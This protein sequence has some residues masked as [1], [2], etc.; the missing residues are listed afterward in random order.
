MANQNGWTDRAYDAVYAWSNPAE[1][2]KVEQTLLAHGLDVRR[3]PRLFSSGGDIFE[4]MER[5]TVVGGQNLLELSGPIDRFTADEQNSKLCHR[6]AP[7]SPDGSKRTPLIRSTPGPNSRPTIGP[8]L[9][10]RRG[11]TV[12]IE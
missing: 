8:T 5:L 6:R 10:H 2:H 4:H 12:G 1:R 9:M 3:D 7:V 11:G